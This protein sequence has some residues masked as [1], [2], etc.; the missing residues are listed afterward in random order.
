MGRA[1]CCDKTKVK[2]GPWAPDEDAKLRHFVETRGNEGNW[3]TLPLKAGLV[4]CGKSCRLR[5]T[6]YLRPNI[7][8]GNFTDEEEKT[9]IDLHRKFG[10]R[11]SMIAAQL[12][13]R[14]D[15]DIKNYWNTRLKKR[16]PENG[17]NSPSHQRHQRSVRQSSVHMQPAIP[18][19]PLDLLCQPSA[20]EQLEFLRQRQQL[21]Q[22]Y[23][24]EQQYQ[25]SQ[26]AYP[27][28]MF[29]QQQL[30]Q[31]QM[32]PVKY[33]R[34]QPSD[35]PLHSKLLQLQSELSDLIRPGS[36]MPSLKSSEDDRSPPLSGD[37]SCVSSELMEAS[38]P[39]GYGSDCGNLSTGC[40]DAFE[41]GQL[42]PMS[43]TVGF[44]DPSSPEGYGSDCGNL[45]GNPGC[46]DA[47]EPI[48]LVV[49]VDQMQMLM[50]M[51][52]IF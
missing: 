21:E 3:I 39:E 27:A 29:F 16:L 41:R 5:W 32:L 30:P 24:I 1:P 12:P 10:T 11:W 7:K 50:T 18:A 31:Q 4:R 6:N 47:F 26:P 17:S 51:S 33:E 52:D 28:R 8:H 2:K 45:S 37:G 23:A 20:L 19:R 46:G 15:N 36:T 44:I 25:Q 35:E 38:S 22:Q 9:I 49:G 34:D 13:G 42:P 14:T 40:G 43:G 48:P